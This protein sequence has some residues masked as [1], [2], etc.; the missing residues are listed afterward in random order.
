MTQNNV[1]DVGMRFIGF[2]ETLLPNK[3]LCYVLSLK[4]IVRVFPTAKLNPVM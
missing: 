3:A 2:G 4:L 1:M